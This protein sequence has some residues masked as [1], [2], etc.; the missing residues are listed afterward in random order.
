MFLFSPRG[1]PL[2][3]TAF[4]DW[5]PPPPVVLCAGFVPA[6]YWF[7]VKLFWEEG[8]CS[9]SFEIG[10]YATLI[11]P[12]FFLFFSSPGASPF[13]LPS[14]NISR[15]SDTELHAATKAQIFLPSLFTWG[16][17]Q[18]RCKPFFAPFRNPFLWP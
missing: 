2:N 3:K 4:C 5:L 6:L 18:S 11:S 9:S 13:L 15:P 17:D 8:L 12:V 10:A 1:P 14:L 16:R 7:T